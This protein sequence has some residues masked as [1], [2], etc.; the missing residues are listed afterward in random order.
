MVKVKGPRSKVKRFKQE[1]VN[2]RT[3]GNRIEYR[4][5]YQLSV[6]VKP[7]TDKISVIGNRLWS[8]IGSTLLAKFNQYAI[9]G[10]RQKHN[11]TF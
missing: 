4:I 1:S 5:E 6:L 9:P 3:G 11:K 7:R 8:N 2:K 10:I